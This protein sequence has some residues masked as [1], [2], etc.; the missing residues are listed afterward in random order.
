MDSK[1]SLHDKYDL[2]S[3]NVPRLYKVS[4]LTDKSIISIVDKYYGMGWD[5]LF[6]SPPYIVMYKK[7]P[8]IKRIQNYLTKLFN[9]KN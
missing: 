9:N 8:L 4:T 7:K 6:I 1:R 5:L 2:L 3:I